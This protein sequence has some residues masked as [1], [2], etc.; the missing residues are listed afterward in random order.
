MKASKFFQSLQFRLIAIVLL[1][2]IV[3]NLVIVTV[4]MKLSTKSTND[5]VDALLNAVSDS[6]AAKIKAEEEKN[7]RMLNAV[8][9]A[10]FLRDDDLPL[11][12]KCA[13]LTRIAKV[14]D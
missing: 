11:R 9:L 4:A 1:V 2:F 13:Q 8:A 12:E 10:D 14:S 5:S 7:F 3:S 6:A